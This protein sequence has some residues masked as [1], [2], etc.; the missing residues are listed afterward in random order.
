M[1][2]LSEYMSI[3]G[4]NIVDTEIFH[5]GIS[6]IMDAVPTKWEFIAARCRDAG[7]DDSADIADKIDAL[8]EMYDARV[9]GSWCAAYL[10]EY[11]K[12][13]SIKSIAS[14]GEWCVPCALHSME[15]DQCG[16]DA[17]GGRNLFSEFLYT[18]H[19]EATATKVGNDA[20]TD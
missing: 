15:C 18:L 3:A 6:A 1:P 9:T 2:T 17:L 13:M 8:L 4:R 5:D 10:N 19:G 14:R 7:Y 11:I 20:N 12:G 16:F